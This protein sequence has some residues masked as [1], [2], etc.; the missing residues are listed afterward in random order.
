MRD[1]QVPYYLYCT[2]G[3]IT[4]AVYSRCWSL[5]PYITKNLMRPHS[6]S[7]HGQNENY[8]HRNDPDHQS[9]TSLENTKRHKMSYVLHMD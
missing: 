8:S 9:G 6:N 5:L 4:C 1:R 3:G 2:E 7:Q